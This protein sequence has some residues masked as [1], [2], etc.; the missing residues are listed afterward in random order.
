MVHKANEHGKLLPAG[1]LGLLKKLSGV[2]S[3]TI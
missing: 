2:S 3:G 1:L